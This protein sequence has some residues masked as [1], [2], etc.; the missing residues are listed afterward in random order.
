MIIGLLLALAAILVLPFLVKQIEH[1][2]ECFLFVMGILAVIISGE[3]SPG[4]FL[5]IFHNEML[6]FITGAVLVAEIGRAHV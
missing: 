3:I 4:L 6:Y 1:N 5:H 2:L